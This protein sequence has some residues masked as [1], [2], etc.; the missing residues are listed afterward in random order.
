M[1]ATTLHVRGMTKKRGKGKRKKRGNNGK[2]KGKK[3][4]NKTGHTITK[5]K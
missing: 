1:Y 4:K 3:K 2:K 5:R